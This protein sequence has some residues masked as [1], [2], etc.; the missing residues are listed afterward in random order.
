MMN[1]DT[2]QEIFKFMFG[3]TRPMCRTCCY[4][5]NGI[6]YILDYVERGYNFEKNLKENLTDQ[7]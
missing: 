2:K 6:S 5:L 4:W 7:E 1:S 3:A